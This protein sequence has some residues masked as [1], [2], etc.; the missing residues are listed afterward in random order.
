MDDAAS[1]MKYGNG[2]GD[3]TIIRTTDGGATWTNQWTGT[4]HH[5]WGVCFTDAN[6]GTV[7]GRGGI[8]L[9]TTDGGATWDSLSSGTTNDL[10]DVCFTDENTGVVVA[11]RGF[12][13]DVAGE[14]F[15]TTDGGE[16]WVTSQ[17]GVQSPGLHGVCFTDAGTGMAVGGGGTILRKSTGVVTSVDE[18]LRAGGYIPS[19]FALQQN[20]PNP[21]NPLTTIEYALPY[22]EFVMLKVYTML[23]EEVETLIEGHHAAGT[24]KAT[25]DAS[26]VP[27]G[28][29]FYRLT[30]G[31]YV[32][33]KKAVLI[34]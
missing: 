20:Y 3:G 27:S 10:W 9:R 14:I 12:G 8:I 33:T 16:T 24:F 6:T 18:G 28:V 15:R 4:P 30:A 22:T 17:L 11:G 13:G 5:F 23:G 34:K 29:Y 7:V 31:G 26:G 2:G 19:G 1:P 32:Q 21:F 25:W